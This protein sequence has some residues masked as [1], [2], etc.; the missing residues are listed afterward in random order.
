MH[1]LA[2]RTGLSLLFGSRQAATAMS[3]VFYEGEEEGEGCAHERI[4][5]SES[6]Q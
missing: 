3:E 5:K 4:S 2:D 1:Y 6:I